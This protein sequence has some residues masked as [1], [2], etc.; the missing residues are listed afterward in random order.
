MAIGETQTGPEGPST[1]PDDATLVH[2]ALEGGPEAFNLIVRR[3]QSAIFGVALARLSDFHDAQDV[4]QQVFV[5]A[6]LRLKTLKDHTRLGGW[7]RTIAIHRSLDLIRRRRDSVP[8]ETLAGA[9][10]SARPDVE[11]ERKEFRGRVLDAIARLSPSQRETTTLFYIDGYSIEEVAAI[12][13]VPSGTAK[14]RLHDARQKLKQEMLVL[15]EDTLKFEKPGSGF[16]KRVYELL[17]RYQNP[18]SEFEWPFTDLVSELSRIGLEG[19][20]GYELAMKSPHA[21]TRQ[22]ASRLVAEVFKEPEVSRERKEVVIRLLKEA[23]NDSSKRVRMMAIRKLMILPEPPE[24]VEEE[25]VPL[26]VERL[27]D[28]VSKVR[29]RAAW[30]LRDWAHC[31]PLERA[32][33]AV[34]DWPPA[35]RLSRRPIDDLVKRI[36]EARS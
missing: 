11:F 2:D 36:V 6:F 7:L 28:P 1:A 30:E 14:R 25:F 29:R 33:L 12:Q 10:S 18:L 27:F 17:S 34:V 20:E 8:L 5:E 35:S 32:A 15:V 21:Q 24:R 4:A 13:E 22:F 31:V 26:V 9:N 19:M 23:V 16:A 3:Y